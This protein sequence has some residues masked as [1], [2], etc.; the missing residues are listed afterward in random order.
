MALQL[1][2]DKETTAVVFLAISLG[3]IGAVAAAAHLL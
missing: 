2:R 3:N 1:R